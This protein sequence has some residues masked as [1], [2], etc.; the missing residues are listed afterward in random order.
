[1]RESRAHLLLSGYYGFGNFGDEA[2]LEIFVREWRR[3]RPLD[4]LTVLSATPD[5]T[6][7]AFGVKAVPRSSFGV[8]REALRR[9]D[10]FVSGGGGLLQTSTSVRSLLYYAGLVHQAAKDNRRSAIFA[11]GIGPLNFAGKQIVRRSCARVDL[12]VVRDAESGAIL[13]ALIPSADVRLGADPVFLAEESVDADSEFDARGPERTLAAEGIPSEGPLVAVV[14]RPSRA[15]ERLS[16]DI[17]AAI[18][19]LA[20]RYGAHVVLIPFQ[21]PVD[22]VACVSII[23]RCGTSPVLLGGGYTLATMTAL[24]RRCSA[25][26]GMRL[27]ALIL[28]ARVGLP[29]LAVPYDPKIEALCSSLSYPLP[30]LHPGTAAD[31]AAQLWEDRERLGAHLQAGSRVLRERASRSFD[32]LQEL[33]EGAAS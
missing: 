21:R 22:V 4:V 6:S 5:L 18:D 19:L 17:A 27:H 7:S 2:I 23:R 8:V 32:W 3:R 20:S 28:A 33:V 1:M 30:P 31:R 26:I 16:A 25:L 15:L 14:V 13:R 12:A 24:F 10:V 29:F 9:C 11:Q